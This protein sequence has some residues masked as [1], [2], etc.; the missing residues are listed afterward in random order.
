[1]QRGSDRRAR[2]PARRRPGAAR[3]L[4]ARGI[5]DIIVVPLRSGQA[6]IGTLEVTNRLSD[7]TTSPPATCRLRD[8]PRTRP[9]PGELPPRRPAAARRLPRHA[10]RTAQPAPGRRRCGEA[11]KI[12]APGEVVAVLLFDVDGLRQVNESLGHAAGDKVLAE[13]AS[14]LRAA[15]RRR[16]WSAASAVTSSLV[17]LRL[18]TPTGRAAARRPAARADRRRWSSATLTLDVDTAVGVAVHPD[19]GSDAETL[20]HGSTWPPPRPSRARAASSCST[21]PWSPGR[22]RRLGLAARPA[23]GARRRRAGGLLPAEGHPAGP[24]AGR[25]GVPGPLG[26]PGARP[27]APED[28]VAVAEHTGQLGG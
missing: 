22:P 25:R 26:A 20:L 8:V 21:R 3:V 4:R 5:K 9:S 15:P 23:P 2:R 1:M 10:D 27:V 19:H 7:T 16:P 18:E 13:V 14:R 17:T 24:P 6:V 11:V 12:R 28:F